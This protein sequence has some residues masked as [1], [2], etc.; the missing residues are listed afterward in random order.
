[1][2]KKC[3]TILLDGIGDRSYP[4]LNHLTPLQAARTPALDRLSQSGANGLYHAAQLGQALP[5]ENAHF[6]MFGYD[7]AAFP[8]R[9][10]LEALGA[11]IPL[12]EGTVAILAHFVSVQR[13]SA[14]TLIL[15]DDSAPATADELRSFFKAV[16]EYE[17]DGIRVR[18][19][20]TQGARAILTLGG[21]VAPFIT[22]SD[23]IALD[24]ELTAVM[25]WQAYGDDPRACKAA[26]AVDAYLQW[27][28]H[29][30][31]R[32]PLNRERQKAGRLPLNGLVT[33]RAGRLKPVA[34]FAELSGLRGLVIASGIIY[35]GLAAY[36]GMDVK[37]DKDTAAPGDDLA[38]RLEM[39]LAAL[40][41]YDFIHV[42]TKAPD[43]AAHTKDPQAKKRVIESLDQG[44]AAVLKKL[45]AAPEL[46]I[47][48]AADHSTPSSGPLVH[49]GEAV[50]LVF[51][52]PGLRRDAV[53]HYDEVSAAGGVL[54][55]V[56]GKEFLYLILNHLD[57]VKL[58]GLMDTPL[59]QSYWPG[60]T[61]P[62]RLDSLP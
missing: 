54:G 56:R 43:A 3:I 13:S 61:T 41:D 33:Q 40:P 26:R 49:S 4:E 5:S 58:H 17:T 31:T 38:R 47:V 32:H 7:M 10:A 25:P 46:L 1:M 35:H 23:P 30:L 45:T 6:A 57:R 52:G 21:D 34:P 50:P 37:R 44:L 62:L 51:C 48:V 18:L 8:G 42:H 28:H 11:G 60:R 24:R 14:G 9:G 29:T 12:D 36:V 59:D 20:P 22:D 53:R 27:A 39:A 16:A 2:A 19:H 15:A 55:V